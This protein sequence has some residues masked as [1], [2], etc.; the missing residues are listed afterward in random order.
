MKRV[1][2]LLVGMVLSF[3]LTVPRVHAITVYD[4]TNH[5]QNILSAIRMLKSNLNEAIAIK[6]QVK[7]LAN[8]FENLKKLPFSVV[9]D[10]DNQMNDL[11]EVTGTINGLMQDFNTLQREFD[12][13]YPDWG[14]QVGIDPEELS[15][16]ANEWLKMS[17]E[18]VLGASKTGSKALEN[19]PRSQEQLTELMSQSQGAAGI[20]Q[21]AQAGN[22]ISGAIAGNLQT[23]V[24]QLATYSQAHMSFMMQQQ[25]AQAASQARSRDAMKGW[26]ERK[27]HM[28]V[29]LAGL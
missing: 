8:E 16:Q 9:D 21:A 10:F 17:R 23:L 15:R 13:L 6:N 18:T 20:L 12:N 11:F 29:P 22:Q 14:N 26:G 5:V 3:G 7:S 24:A 4:P 1:V 19:L 25:A 28:S 27:S 2:G